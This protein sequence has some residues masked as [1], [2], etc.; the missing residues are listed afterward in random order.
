MSLRSQW[1]LI[2]SRTVVESQS[3]HS[4][5][6]RISGYL[7]ASSVLPV[8]RCILIGT[9]WECDVIGRH[10]AQSTALGCTVHC[11]A[12]C[13][14]SAARLLFQPVA[15]PLSFLAAA[16]WPRS[17]FYVTVVWNFAST[18][19]Y[20]TCRVCDEHTESRRNVQ[21]IHRCT[22]MLLQCERSVL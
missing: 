21:Q 7:C 17:C 10:S 6:Q 3:N 2:S 4:C 5:N 19:S 8:W 16:S 20:V 18:A 9:Q 15:E 12:T 14:R 13:R 11:S 22:C 1:V